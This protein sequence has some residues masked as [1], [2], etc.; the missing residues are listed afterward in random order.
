MPAK[1]P[2]FGHLRK[3]FPIAVEKLRVSGHLIPRHGR[4]PNTSV[5]NRP[6]LIYYRCFPPAATAETM[7]M[8]L[9]IAGAVLPRPPEAMNTATHFHDDSYGVLAVC[10]GNARLCFGGEKNPDRVEPIVEKGDVVIIPPGVGYRILEELERPFRVIAAFPPGASRYC[11]LDFGP[12]SEPDRTDHV[13]QSSCLIRD[14][15]YGP[16]GPLL[17]SS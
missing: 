13:A 11:H 16:Q 14:P 6:L 3:T 17:A 8:Q 1:R 12:E 4:I 10:D 7:Q 5:Q 2:E 15:I 9:R